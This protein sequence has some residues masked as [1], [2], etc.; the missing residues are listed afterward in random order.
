MLIQQ[1][2]A[3]LICS[4]ALGGVSKKPDAETH[5]WLKQVPLVLLSLDF[6]EAGKK[7]YTFWMKLYPNLSP[8]PSPFAKS[9]GDAITTFSID[10]LKWISPGLT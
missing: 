2:A 10:V 4:L 1:E 5:K 6:D 7:H 9:P 3:H 8:W